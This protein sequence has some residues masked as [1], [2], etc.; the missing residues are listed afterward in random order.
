M[1]ANLPQMYLFLGELPARGGAQVLLELLHLGGADD[2]R[3]HRRGLQQPAQ[4]HLTRGLT[5]DHEMLKQ[6]YSSLVPLFN[7]GLKLSVTELGH[8]ICS[9]R[10]M[11]STGFHNSTNTNKTRTMVLCD[12]LHCTHQSPELVVLQG[13]VR[14][15]EVV[16]YLVE[17]DLGPYLQTT[18]GGGLRVTAPELPGQETAG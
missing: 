12:S 9:T 1:R 17:L 11:T 18:A 2:D 5:C 14:I 4:R 3:G 6:K 7:P 15:R 8:L 10:S 16:A 13:L